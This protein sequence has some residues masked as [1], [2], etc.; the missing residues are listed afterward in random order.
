VRQT[1]KEERAA[2]A[3]LFKGQF[4]FP[5][6]KPGSSNQDGGSTPSA[7]PGP[8]DPTRSAERAAAAKAALQQLKS[9][10]GAGGA[11]SRGAVASVLGW[12]WA[13]LLWLGS[14]MGLRKGVSQQPSPSISGPTAEDLQATQQQ[15]EAEQQLQ[16]SEAEPVAQAVSDV[17]AGQGSAVPPEVSAAAQEDM[18]ASAPAKDSPGAVQ[19]QGT[20]EE[21]SESKEP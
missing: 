19:E 5:D 17:R 12:L 6:P 14:L 18:T 1:I 21:S 2:E 16:S 15:G 13:L 11:S 7:P 9:Q 20:Q 4:K 3:K 10:A 8:P